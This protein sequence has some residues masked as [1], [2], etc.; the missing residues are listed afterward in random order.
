VSR[1]ARRPVPATSTA[2]AA[3]LGA[4]AIAGC[5]G[6]GPAGETSPLGAGNPVAAVATPHQ[7]AAGRRQRHVAVV[8]HRSRPAAH[9]PAPRRAHGSTSA[10]SPVATGNAQA[11]DKLA[12]TVD[13]PRASGASAPAASVAPLS[14]GQ[15]AAAADAICSSY[16][17][18]VRSTG[19]SAVTLITQENELSTLVGE[20][21]IALKRVHAL[22]P[23]AGEAAL[24]GTFIALTRASVGEFVKA[25]THS[26]STSEAV[27]TATEAKDMALAQ[28]SG[29][30]A[31]GAQAAAHRLG[32]HVCGSLGAE[33]L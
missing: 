25:Q 12:A 15:F 3:V 16:R 4:V 32:L 17:H 10:F 11:L 21:A 26:N 28:S 5:G 30:D 14:S 22:P 13:A 27:G 8:R 29:K 19:A 20:T 18:T 9:K 1:L 24:V 7:A 23:P 6:S 33:W 31:L 2:L